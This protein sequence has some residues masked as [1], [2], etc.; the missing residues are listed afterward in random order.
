MVKGDACRTVGQYLEN[1]PEA[2]VSLAYFDFDIYEPTR[3]VL[4]LIK[5]RLTNGSVVCFDELNDP[6]CPGE[7]RAVMEVLGLN[8]VRLKKWEYCTKPCWF[9]V[10]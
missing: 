8:S 4:E 6:N 3:E 10:E 1:N 2:V 9:V 7:T 5:N